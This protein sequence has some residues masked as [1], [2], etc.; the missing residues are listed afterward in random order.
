MNNSKSSC[1][2]LKETKVDFAHSST[3]SSNESC[4]FGAKR[5]RYSDSPKNTK[6]KKNDYSSMQ[7]YF[8]KLEKCSSDLNF[9]ICKTI[10]TN[11][12]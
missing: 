3:S 2:S 8:I 12:F 5:K 6:R 1:S 7:N 4:A 9:F 10:N 11:F